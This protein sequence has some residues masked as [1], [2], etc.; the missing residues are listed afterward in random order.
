MTDILAS[1]GL[2]QMERYEKTLQKRRFIVSSYNQGLSH[3]NI[4]VLPHLNKNKLSSCHLYIVRL[5]GFSIEE[6]N[7]FISLMGER[8]IACN[9]HYKPL[10]M[11]SAY[12]KLG[13]DIKN[14]KNAYALYSIEVTLP[15]HTK[16]SKKDIHRIVDAFK[17][18]YDEIKTS[19]EKLDETSK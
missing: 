8:G 19:N 4:S 13:F 2:T 14:F 15:L 12:K 16:L 10:P 11:F 5:N 17:S 1:I 18:A 9:V 7:K 6:R 3:L